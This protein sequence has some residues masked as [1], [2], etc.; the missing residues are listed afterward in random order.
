MKIFKVTSAR[1]V[2]FLKITS[3]K[4]TYSVSNLALPKKGTQEF[5]KTRFE[6][7]YTVLVY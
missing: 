1:P 3:A 7:V 2:P 4:F 5:G 6:T